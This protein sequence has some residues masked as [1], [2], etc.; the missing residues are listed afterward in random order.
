MTKQTL[1]KSVVLAGF[2]FC[3]FLTNLCA[4][5]EDRGY[6]KIQKLEKEAEKVESAQEIL[7]RPKVEYN[8]E[9]YEDPFEGP[10][11]EQDAG[12][13]VSGAQKK[14]L[15]ALTVQGV[16]W[17]GIFPQAIINNK[18]VKVGDII[19]GVRILAIDKEGITIFFEGDQFKL[20]SPA[21]GGGTA[22]KEK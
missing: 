10:V 15:P 11:I 16:V 7:A 8:A 3:V 5:Q 2:I 13:V 12:A 17:G 22:V 14:P 18:V 21:A 9:T 6:K 1:Q 20:P 19:E 4:A